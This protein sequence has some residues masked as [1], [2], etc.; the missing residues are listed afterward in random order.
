MKALTST[1]AWAVSHSTNLS[2]SILTRWESCSPTWT[3]STESA[4]FIC[5]SIDH[6]S[7][8]RLT[9]PAA[10]RSQSSQSSLVNNWGYRIKPL[11]PVYGPSRTN[12]SKWTESKTTSRSHVSNLQ[13]TTLEWSSKQAKGAYSS[14]TAICWI[15]VGSSSSAAKTSPATSTTEPLQPP[16]IRISPTRRS[17][18]SSILLIRTKKWWIRQIEAACPVQSHQVC[19]IPRVS[20]LQVKLSRSSSTPKQTMSQFNNKAQIAGTRMV[21]SST[22]Y[23]E[24]QSAISYRKKAFLTKLPWMRLEQVQPPLPTLSALSSEK[25]VA[26]LTWRSSWKIKPYPPRWHEQSIGAAAKR[27]C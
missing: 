21:Q 26:I 2:S 7:S 3:T 11:A 14:S 20:S 19:V 13:S 12:S 5:R 1:R 6:L 15:T 10:A 4:A 18:R 22:P 9:S 24:I 27:L 16:I 17:R 8:A 23:A 25:S